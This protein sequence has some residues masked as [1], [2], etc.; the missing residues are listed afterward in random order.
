MT[1]V[2]VTWCRTWLS[3]I[4]LSPPTRMAELIERLEEVQARDSMSSCGCFTY[5][6]HCMC[7]YHGVP[8]FE[9][10]AWVSTCSFLCSYIVNICWIQICRVFCWFIISLNSINI[11]VINKMDAVC[12]L[13]QYWN[14]CA[15]SLITF[16]VILPVAVILGGADDEDIVCSVGLLGHIFRCSRW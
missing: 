1:V 11:L 2:V 9:E 3:R 15:L 4:S 5:A 8:F 16:V 6:Y 10:V 7:D 13:G 14:V 12:S